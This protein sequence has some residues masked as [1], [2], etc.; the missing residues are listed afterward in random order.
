MILFHR[1]DNI[2]N[3]HFVELEQLAKPKGIFFTKIALI[4]DRYL[5]KQPRALTIKRNK[6]KCILFEFPLA[7]KGKRVN[8]SQLLCLVAFLFHSLQQLVLGS[9]QWE[10]VQLTPTSFVLPQYFILSRDGSNRGC[11]K[12]CSSALTQ[13]EYL[14]LWRGS[15]CSVSCMRCLNQLLP[16][17]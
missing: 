16:K 3:E 10:R 8:F 1:E 12:A 4:H 17:V 11:W 6:I 5:Q 13:G 15:S 7:L 9:E 14:R 2:S